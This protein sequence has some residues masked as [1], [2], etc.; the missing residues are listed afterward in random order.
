MTP[1]AFD[2]LARAES[3]WWYEGR[4]RAVTST[5]IANHA[6][7]EGHVLDFGAGHGGM[8]DVLRA[9]GSVTAYEP[10]ATPRASCE[11]RGYAACVAHEADLPA[12]HGTFQLIGAFDVLE[13]VKQDVETLRLL[14]SLLVPGGALILTVP[15][16]P[17]LW[18]AHDTSHHHHRR[19]T[20][21]ILRRALEEA[22]F[23][24]RSLGFWN[25]VLGLAL[26]PLRLFGFAGGDGLTP[27]RPINSILRMIVGTEA[28]LLKYTRLP[29]GSSLICYA[30]R[31]SE[32]R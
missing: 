15:A 2:L 16:W 28:H 18:S 4:A 23:T 12:L 9:F 19:Y 31:P 7:T 6:R 29:F 14:R 32:P 5:L 8:V 13:H 3:S 24:V 27:A 21:K 17:I 1:E 20:P 22:G 11:R 26:V 25:C 10:D 30:E